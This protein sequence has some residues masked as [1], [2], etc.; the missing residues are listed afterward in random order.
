LVD[1]EAHAETSL[2]MP[3]PTGT[4]FQCAQ[5]REYV[6]R[7]GRTTL[8]G[9]E[10]AL[11]AALKTYQDKLTLVHFQSERVAR[12]CTALKRCW[13]G[14][15][16]S[17][18][19]EEF[20]GFVKEWTQ[21][22]YDLCFE[23][24]ALRI[25]YDALAR[26]VVRTLTP[27]LQGKAPERSFRR[28]LEWLEEHGRQ[29]GVPPEVMAAVCGREESFKK[30]RDLRDKFVHW[31]DDTLIVRM[32]D[33]ELGF[34]VTRGGYPWV[35]LEKRAGEGV[36]ALKPALSQ[37][38]RDQLELAF[39]LE[40][41]YLAAQRPPVRV[42]GSTTALPAQLR[43]LYGLHSLNTYGVERFHLDPPPA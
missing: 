11:L 5:Q 7:A 25:A 6:A 41:C 38:I 36:H 39:E 32:A 4:M 13:D 14:L 35:P 2:P 1:E 12:S 27:K 21:L 23:F 17:S 22:R 20:E 42:P 30:L 31:D 29:K 40:S 9:H 24:V 43:E 10:I 16:V 37:I 28:L 15:V 26:V 19:H 3:T 8:S 33:G 34:V 18:G